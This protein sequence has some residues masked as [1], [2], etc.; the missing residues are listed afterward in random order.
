MPDLNEAKTRGSL[1]NPQLGRQTKCACHPKCVQPGGIGHALEQRALQTAQDIRRSRPAN[2]IGRRRRAI[3]R[4]TPSPGRCAP[5]RQ[6][7]CAA[8][9]APGRCRA[10]RRR[11]TR[12]AEPR[13]PRCLAKGV[14][15]PPPRAGVRAPA[16][17]ARLLPEAPGS[18]QL[19]IFWP[20]NREPDLPQR[21]MLP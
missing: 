21:W 14:A 5:G 10:A 13:R 19:I 6:H 20:T 2:A 18:E 17:A 16:G 8:I 11:V 15:Q 1:I 3:A 9:R 4:A 7:P 12:H